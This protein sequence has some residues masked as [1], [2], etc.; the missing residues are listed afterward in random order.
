M[1]R[2]VWKLTGD[3]LKTTH[4][5]MLCRI[6]PAFFQMFNFPW[7][8]ETVRKFSGTPNGKDTKQKVPGKSPSMPSTDHVQ[9]Q[10]EGPASSQGPA[11]MRQR[12]TAGG[13][14]EGLTNIRPLALAVEKKDFHEC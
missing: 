2:T 12:Q 6:E 13:A 1:S 11:A 9:S 4:V 3:V 10:E 14:K 5:K 7:E 8:T